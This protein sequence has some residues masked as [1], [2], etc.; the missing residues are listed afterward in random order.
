MEQHIGRTWVRAALVLLSLPVTA[1]AQEFAGDV[2][3]EE[4]DVRL[5]E[6]EYSPYLNR[7]Y[8]Q[9]VFW[10]DAH[11]HTSYSTDAGMLG[12]YLGPDEAAAFT[13]ALITSSFFSDDGESKV[14]RDKI[15][16][17]SF[18]CGTSEPFR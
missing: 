15:L 16:G 17:I 12:N 3:I 8:P 5:G 1:S 11:V 7:G 14:A 9:R 10:G 2:G 18:H 13:R 6:P 4:D